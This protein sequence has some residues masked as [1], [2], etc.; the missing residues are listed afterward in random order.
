MYLLVAVR[1]SEGFLLP[2]HIVCYCILSFDIM[3]VSRHHFT[4]NK[5]IMLI[6][7]CESCPMLSVLYWRYVKC[8]I[9]CIIYFLG[10]IQNFQSSMLKQWRL[11]LCITSWW[12]KT[13]CI[14][15]MQ[16]Y[17]TNSIICSHRVFLALRYV[18]KL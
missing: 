11:F 3:A 18:H 4:G 14:P 1:R 8:R 13:Q 16:S 5:S 2:G 10:N 15:C 17:K 9:N 7:P 6:S 12:M